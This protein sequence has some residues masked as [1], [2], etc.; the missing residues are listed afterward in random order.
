MG[1]FRM[2]LSKNFIECYI[3]GKLEYKPTEIINPRILEKVFL[4][5][6]GDGNPYRVEFDKISYSIK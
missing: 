2:C 3:N 6:W 5:A 4:V 1:K